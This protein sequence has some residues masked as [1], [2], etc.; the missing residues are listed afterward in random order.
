MIWHLAQRYRA[1]ILFT[2]YLQISL[3]SLRHA[4][5]AHIHAHTRIS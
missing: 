5:H 4:R 1:A 2:G 3:S